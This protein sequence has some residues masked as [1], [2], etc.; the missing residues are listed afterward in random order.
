MRPFTRSLNV[1]VALAFLTGGAVPSIAAPTPPPGGAN[2]ISAIPGTVGQRV[3]N[4]VLRVTIQS[5]HD[6]TADDHPEKELPSADQKII[7]MH[8]L[9]NNGSHAVFN[10][11]MV[12]TLADA[13]NVTVQVSQ[14]YVHPANFS[15]EQGASAKQTIR[16]PVDKDFKPVK[17]L[18]ECGGC[19]TSQHFRPLRITIPST[20]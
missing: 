13:D 17:V 2:Q 11:L 8:V 1:F 14:P 20:P 10:S 18:V 3:F 19:G 7:V 12:Y 15:I 5:I 6:A 4:G 16:V 9:L